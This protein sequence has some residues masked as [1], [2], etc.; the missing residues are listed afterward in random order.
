EV[1]A[2]L[3]SASSGWAVSTDGDAIL[4]KTT[5]PE[6]DLPWQ[7]AEPRFAIAVRRSATILAGTGPFRLERL[8]AGRLTLRAHDGSRSGRPCGDGVEIAMGRTSAAQLT[9]LESGRADVV[10]V[11][12]A[13]ARRL[14]ERGLE[15]VAAAPSDVYALVFEPHR[16]DDASLRMRQQFA[17]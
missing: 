6:P 2:A 16:A 4:L 10:E 7:L 12:A 15:V 14:T 8:E 11:Q 3:R 9:D 17:G 5:R 13:D 1:A